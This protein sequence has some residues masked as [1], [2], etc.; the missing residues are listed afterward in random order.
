MKLD[1]RQLRQIVESTLN[2]RS[3]SETARLKRVRADVEVKMLERLNA[4][5]IPHGN[6]YLSAYLT[7]LESDVIVFGLEIPG[8]EEYVGAMSKET[9]EL[10]SEKLNGL[11]G[12]FGSNFEI[13]VWDR[14]GDTELYGVFA[15]YYFK[16]S[17][18]D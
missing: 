16:M 4:G 10:L 9:A 7:R 17:S 5:K 6:E 12:F 15:K 13:R 8:Y 2:E 3:D 11:G 14:V 18:N 1:R